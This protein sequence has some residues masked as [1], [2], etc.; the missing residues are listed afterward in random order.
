MKRRSV[1]KCSAIGIGLAVT[2][3]ACALQTDVATS[4]NTAAIVLTNGVNLCPPA[5]AEYPAVIDWD[6]DRRS[7]DELSALADQ[8]DA[9]AMVM[10]GL[11]YLPSNAGT[12]ADGAARPAT[13]VAK[14]LGL[15]RAAAKKRHGHAEFLVGVAFMSGEGAAKDEKMALEWFTRAAA[16][17]STLGQFWTGEMIAKGRAGMAED[18]KSALPYFAKAAAG[19]L[20]DAYVELGYAYVSGL[21]GLDLDYQK[22]GFCYRQGARLK[23][24]VAQFGVLNLIYEGHIAW[25]EGDPGAPPGRTPITPGK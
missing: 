23:S 4:A 13:D 6:L 20:A 15:F 11:R 18:W 1:F 5:K 8:G 9:N 12:S 10:L 7:L 16:D 22:A 17:G 2:L 25:Q 3:S 24:Q 14:A 19:G 21:G